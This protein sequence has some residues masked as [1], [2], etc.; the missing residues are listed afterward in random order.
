MK[1]DQEW[2]E[3]LEAGKMHFVRITRLQIKAIQ[4][5]A[6][7]HAYNVARENEIYNDKDYSIS[8]DILGEVK[9]LS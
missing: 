7:L 2:M 9:K 6:L 5:D 3:S 4:K 8:W 1:T